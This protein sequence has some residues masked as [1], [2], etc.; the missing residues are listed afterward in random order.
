MENNGFA[1]LL[2]LALGTAASLGATALAEPVLSPLVAMPVAA[3]NPVLGADDKIHLAYEVTLVN[4]S[5]LLVSIEAIDVVDAANEQA[6]QH[7]GHVEL[8]RGN[9]AENDELQQAFAQ[10]AEFFAQLSHVSLE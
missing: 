10:R 4:Q 8:L 5:Q 2:G 3:P 1:L 7:L 9:H 6:L